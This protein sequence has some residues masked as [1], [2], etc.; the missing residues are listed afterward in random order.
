MTSGE[1]SR[2]MDAAAREAGARRAG[3]RPLAEVIFLTP[4]L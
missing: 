3:A 1:V 2:G 4:R